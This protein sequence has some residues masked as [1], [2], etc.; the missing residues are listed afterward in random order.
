[1]VRMG[2]GETEMTLLFVKT[3]IHFLPFCSACDLLGDKYAKRTNV[4]VVIDEAH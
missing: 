3:T 1:M 2:L 4:L